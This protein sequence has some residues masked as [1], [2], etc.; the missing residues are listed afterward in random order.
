MFKQKYRLITVT[1]VITVITVFI[2][3]SCEKDEKEPLITD[4]ASVV[5]ELSYEQI[6][7]IGKMHNVYIERAYNEYLVKQKTKSTIEEDDVIMDIIDLISFFQQQ[8]ESL[9]I[10]DDEINKI[11]KFYYD[12]KTDENSNLSNAEQ[13][14]NYIKSNVEAQY[15]IDYDNIINAANTRSLIQNQTI[16]NLTRVASSV[17]E[18]SGIFWKDYYG[19]NITRAALGSGTI[20]ADT[21]GALWGLFFGPVGSIIVGG[22]ASIVANEIEN[23]DGNSPVF[24]GKIHTPKDI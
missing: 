18:Y 19:D 21:G 2:F 1:V 4:V 12:F 7:Y 14:I 8:P 22:V 6:E 16:N 5:T 3:K 24:D 13:L 15:G 23:A 11:K 17:N 9:G 10:N 20:A